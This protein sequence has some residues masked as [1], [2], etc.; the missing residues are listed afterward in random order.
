MPLKTGD[1]MPARP[2][3]LP[4][5]EGPPGPL[6]VYFYPRDFTSVCTREACE[7][8]DAYDELR[9]RHGVEIVGVSRDSEERHAGFK[10]E[11]RL[12]FRLLSDRGGE[13]AKRF[14]VARLWGLIP[15]TKRVT[16][17]ADAKD[18]IR[19]V[20]LH[21]LDAAAHVRDVK[22]CLSGLS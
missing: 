20:F 7:F 12:N 13:L 19:G 22:A 17:V 3:G 1:P 8:R 4:W 9:G 2:D 11:H 6:V 16:F 14:G 21:E 15:L 18:I 5:R 10:A